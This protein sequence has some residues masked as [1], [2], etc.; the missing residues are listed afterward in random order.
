M[1]SVTAPFGTTFESS[2]EPYLQHILVHSMI[3]SEEEK[4]C[5]DITAKPKNA[6][7]MLNTK[8]TIPLVVKP[9]GNLAG[10]P[11]APSRFKRSSVRPAALP[12]VRIFW[13]LQAW[14]WSSGI[15]SVA[16][17]S[18]GASTMVAM[19]PLATCHSMWQWKSQ[20]RKG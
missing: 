10:G 9:S 6:D 12:A 17:N 5:H 13:D 7:K 11:V 16:C 4:T 2:L 1:K 14:R 8:A 19:R 3:Q 20:I 18:S 15:L